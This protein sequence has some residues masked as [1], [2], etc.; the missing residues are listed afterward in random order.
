MK[1]EWGNHQSPRQPPLWSCGLV[2]PSSTDWLPSASLWLLYM[3]NHAY[4]FPSPWLSSANISDSV[5]Q[6]T[7]SKFARE[8]ADGTR[9]ML[10]PVLIQW[11]WVR[12]GWIQEVALAGPFWNPQQHV[13]QLLCLFIITSSWI[14]ACGHG[15]WSVCMEHLP[16][17]Y[18][19]CYSILRIQK[20]KKTWSL[21][22]CTHGAVGRTGIN[23]SLW[24]RTMWALTEV[25]RELWEVYRAPIRKPFLTL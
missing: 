5:V 8:A 17:V 18:Q 19:A 3:L 12:N 22:S 13:C 4:G 14:R 24:Y 6:G 9:W 1:P 16:H 21:S 15:M 20:K 2:P 23:W 7:T 25:Y 10:V 11:S